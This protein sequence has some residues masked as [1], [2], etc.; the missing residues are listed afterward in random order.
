MPNHTTSI[1]RAPAE[2]IASFIHRFGPASLD[3]IVPF[4]GSVKL[5]P[6]GKELLSIYRHYV[7]F[8]NQDINT[9]TFYNKK[10]AAFYKKLLK[11][12]SIEEQQLI[13]QICSK[14]YRFDHIAKIIEENPNKDPRLPLM[15][16]W[17]HW[18]VDNWDT[19]F[20]LTTSQIKL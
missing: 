12:V 18:N 17:Y 15:G 7:T 1:I 14:N 16:S 11:K 6:A 20:K 19:K 4:Q 8:T 3:S 9:Q 2:V 13:Q 10:E 5:S